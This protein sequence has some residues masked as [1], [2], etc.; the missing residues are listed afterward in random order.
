LFCVKEGIKALGFSVPFDCVS[1]G[2][3]QFDDNQE[4]DNDDFGRKVKPAR[5]FYTGSVVNLKTYRAKHIQQIGQRN[6]PQKRS[7]RARVQ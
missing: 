5:P 6:E 1:H 4:S 7:P 3:L 2:R